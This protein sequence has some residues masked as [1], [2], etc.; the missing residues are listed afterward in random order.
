M[1]ACFHVGD[2][3]LPLKKRDQE[4]STWI[5]PPKKRNLI[6]IFYE[7]DFAFPLKK[8]KSFLMFDQEEN[9]NQQ[10]KIEG[11]STTQESDTDGEKMQESVEDVGGDD[12]VQREEEENVVKDT[13]MM[14]DVPNA[15]VEEVLNLMEGGNKDV[16]IEASNPISIIAIAASWYTNSSENQEIESN[17]TEGQTSNKEPFAGNSTKSDDQNGNATD[18]SNDRKRFTRPRSRIARKPRAHPTSLA[19]DNAFAVATGEVIK[20]KEQQ[21]QDLYSTVKRRRG[22]MAAADERDSRCSRVN[23]KG[24]RCSQETREGYA[25]CDHH[26]GRQERLRRT[27]SQLGSSIGPKKKP[28]RKKKGT[29]QDIPTSINSM[30]D[31][32]PETGKTRTME[33]IMKNS[34][35]RTL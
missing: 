22:R 9:K 1:H 19:N 31:S 30:M 20:D 18:Q 28:G 27:G 25:L 7:N 35:P 32:P 4:T 24:W 2:K 8:R 15:R 21:Q 6:C 13:D 33:S 26:L 12:D 17:G 5:L 29:D 23:G 3:L 10:C 16:E 11:E 34:A 14:F